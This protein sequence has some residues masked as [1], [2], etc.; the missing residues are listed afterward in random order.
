MSRFD[1]VGGI[2][3]MGFISPMDTNDTYAVIDPIYGVDGLRNV[4]SIDDLHYIS[5]ERRRPG[6]IVGVGGGETYYKLK[7]LV[8]WSFD[9][10]DW[11]EL[12]LSKI[13]YIDKEK[14]EGS[15]DGVNATF[16]LNNNPIPGSE[17]IYLNGLLQDEIDD[18]TIEYNTI[19]FIEV[20]LIGMKIKCSYR[21]Q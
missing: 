17:H 14:P 21:T 18:Y 9:I 5:F 7:N 10:T 13:T 6:M 19:T 8:D 15:I 1:L 11:D 20:P 3:V 2:G 4:P 12:D 16:L